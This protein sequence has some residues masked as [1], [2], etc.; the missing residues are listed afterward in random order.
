MYICF[1]IVHLN[2]DFEIFCFIIFSKANGCAT[3]GL[4]SITLYHNLFFFSIAE[5]KSREIENAN[6][7]NLLGSKA[8]KITVRTNQGGV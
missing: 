3:L 6:I 7:K 2:L 4:T 8:I 5:G 1:Y